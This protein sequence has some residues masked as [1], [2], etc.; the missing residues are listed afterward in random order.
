L[1]DAVLQRKR[2]GR[3]WRL[4][5]VQGLQPRARVSDP[6][7]SSGIKVVLPGLP[8]IRLSL[9]RPCGGCSDQG[10]SLNRAIL[11]RIRVLSCIAKHQ[12]DLRSDHDP[13]SRTHK[14]NDPDSDV[15]QVAWA[16]MP[17]APSGPSSHDPCRCAHTQKNGPGIDD[18]NNHEGHAAETQAMC[19]PD[20][21][22]QHRSGSSGHVTIIARQPSR[23]CLRAASSTAAPARPRHSI[24]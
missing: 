1:R 5:L 6:R 22:S 21:T 16:F 18:R 14:Q 9:R 19:A 12:N 23:S 24:D 11:P 20:I 15:M 2:I 8:R 7:Y 17:I 4:S 13:N 10:P 3:A